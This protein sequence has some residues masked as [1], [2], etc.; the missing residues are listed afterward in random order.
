MILRRAVLAGIGGMALVGGGYA[1]GGLP[2]RDCGGGC[3]GR[4]PEQHDRH[5]RRPA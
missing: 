2:D 3:G 4:P 5:D 1:A